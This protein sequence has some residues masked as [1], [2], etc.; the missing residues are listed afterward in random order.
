MPKLSIIIPTFNSA[1]TIQRCLHSV[2][3]Q[4]FTDYEIVIQDG[5]S[6]DRTLEFISE[7]RRENPGV[8]IDLKQEPD[9]G[10]YD[11]IN[12]AIRRARGEWLH[13][14][15]SDDELY[16][17]DVL[18]K[19][20]GIPDASDSDALYGNIQCIGRMGS[21]P[22]GTIYDGP[23]NLIKLLNENI[24]HQAIFYKAVFVAEVGNYNQK[25]VIQADWDFN[26]RCWARGRFRYVDMVVVK[27][28][29]GG[30]TSQGKRDECFR[31]DMA[32]NVVQYFGFSIFSPTVNGPTFH[33]LGG[34]AKMQR[35]KGS[36]YYVAGRVL[37][38]ALRL[39]GANK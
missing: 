18:N 3:E 25:Y 4:T 22:D 23:F 15:G 2:R 11:A 36:V 26:L 9:N 35:A 16:A 1:G 13:F 14:L 30:I 21:V 29:S 32:A 19:M 31:M 20:L 5:G 10:V 6:S 38:L 24:C 28:Y 39:L 7:F 37:R 17:P 12:K 33:W 8:M 34:I 27:F